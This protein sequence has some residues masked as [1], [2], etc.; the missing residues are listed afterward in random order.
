MTTMITTAVA[1]LA[2]TVACLAL[3]DLIAFR[4]SVVRPLASKN[5]Y[6]TTNAGLFEWWNFLEV[7]L[8]YRFLKT[9]CSDSSADYVA[10]GLVRRVIVMV[11]FAIL[12]VAMVVIQQVWIAK[13]SNDSGERNALER[14][15]ESE[16]VEP[17]Q[18]PLAALSSTSPVT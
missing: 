11:A 4:S 3:L 18:P 8:E 13:V 6:K 10:A 15:E 16:Q 9:D 7:Y 5:G 2:F 1:L 12:L 14:K 17:Q